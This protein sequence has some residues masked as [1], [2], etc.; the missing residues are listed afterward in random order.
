MTSAIHP[1]L[2]QLHYPWHW[3]AYGQN[4]VA[5]ELVQT[6]AVNAFTVV[7]SYR[8]LVLVNRQA[9]EAET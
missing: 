8:T 9:V 7:V 2:D 1:W 5:L 3:L 6:A 4:G